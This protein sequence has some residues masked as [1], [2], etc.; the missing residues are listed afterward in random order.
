MSCIEIGCGI[1]RPVDSICCSI[2]KQDKPRIF[3][4]SGLMRILIPKSTMS[5]EIFSRSSLI[6]AK[7]KGYEG[8]KNF[9]FSTT[10]YNCGTLL[11]KKKDGRQ[12][13]SNA[14]ETTDAYGK[15]KIKREFYRFLCTFEIKTSTSA[16]FKVKQKITAGVVKGIDLSFASKGGRLLPT[17]KKFLASEKRMDVAISNMIAKKYKLRIAINWCYLSVSKWIAW[18]NGKERYLFK[19]GSV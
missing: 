7:C 2:C 5:K 18:M 6:D 9:I 13:Y 14:I 15:I 11:H 16:F 12:S 17:K 10:V 1:E 4:D 3:C 19:N 8:N